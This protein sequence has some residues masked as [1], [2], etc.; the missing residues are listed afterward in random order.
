M[1]ELKKRSIEKA[2]SKK[3]RILGLDP[4]SYDSELAFYNDLNEKYKEI[5]NDQIKNINR[6]I[7]IDRHRYKILTFLGLISNTG[8]IDEIEFNPSLVDKVINDCFEYNDIKYKKNFNIKEKLTDLDFK[9]LKSYYLILCYRQIKNKYLIKSFT[10]EIRSI[11]SSYWN[12]YISKYDLYKIATYPYQEFN[13]KKFINYCDS[14]LL[15]KGCASTKRKKICSDIEKFL[16][17]KSEDFDRDFINLQEL[18]I[19]DK[20]DLK[21]IKSKFKEISGLEFN[22]DNVI[23]IEDFLDTIHSLD[24]II[25]N[26]ILYKTDELKTAIENNKT[27]DPVDLDCAY[28]CNVDLATLKRYQR[29]CDICDGMNWNNT[30]IFNNKL[31]NLPS[32]KDFY[33][34]TDYYKIDNMGFIESIDLLMDMQKLNKKKMHY[35]RMSNYLLPLSFLYNRGNTWGPMMY[36]PSFLYLDNSID[37]MATYMYMIKPGTKKANIKDS[38]YYEKGKDKN[39]SELNKDENKNNIDCKTMITTIPKSLKD[40]QL[41]QVLNNALKYGKNQMFVFDSVDSFLETLRKIIEQEKNQLKNH[42]HVFYYDNNL[43]KYCKIQMTIRPNYYN[44]YLVNTPHPSTYLK[45]L[46]NDELCFDLTKE[47]LNLEESMDILNSN[48]YD[49]IRQLMSNVINNKKINND[50]L[51]N[52]FDTTVNKL[53]KQK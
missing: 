49:V 25:D 21:V 47:L 16:T 17:Q 33:D 52:D 53:I 5:S 48:I 12:Y 50:D 27:I 38:Y 24:Q 40:K 15:S 34:C 42:G 6:K 26:D 1:A 41:N 7:E 9:I 13:K 39:I 8:V 31:L 18:S 22:K 51:L 30:I 36:L 3:R 37:N 46:E 45:D 29:Y 14:V 43:K 44:T 10:N 19:E 20:D 32:K 2:L 35:I 23:R 28:E 11:A 4:K